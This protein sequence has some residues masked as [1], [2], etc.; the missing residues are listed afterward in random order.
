M[1]TK[2]YVNTIYDERSK[3]IIIGLTGRTGSGCSE[4]AKILETE[5]FCDLHLRVPKNQDYHTKDDRKYRIVYDYAKKNW[6]PFFVLKMSDIIFS[7][8]LQYEFDELNMI[9]RN[10]IEHWDDNF[11]NGFDENF[12]ESYAL[13]HD[14]LKSLL[15]AEKTLKR[16]NSEQLRKEFE[17]IARVT[18]LHNSFK[19]KIRKYSC[20]VGDES[21]RANVYSYLWQNMANFIRRNG[22]IKDINSNSVNVFCLARRANDFI[23]AIRKYNNSNRKNTLICIDAFR[24]AYEAQYFQ[25]RYAAFYLVSINTEESERRRRLGNLTDEQI[26]NLDEIESPKKFKNSLDKFTNQ[27]I[28]ACLELSDIHLYNPRS[29]TKENFYLAKQLIKY[30]VLMKHPGIVTP[31]HIERCM[32]IACNAKLN[33]G[34]LSRQVGACITDENYSVKAIGWNDV[35]EGQIPCNLRDINDLVKNKDCDTFSTY[36]IEDGKFNEQV[37]EIYSKINFDILNGRCYQY[38]FK[39]VFNSIDNKKNQVHTRA[40][41]AEENVFLQ[42]SKYGGIG[43]K[44]GNLFTT[45]SPCELCSKKAYQLGIKNIYYID[46]YPGISVKHI[47]SFKNTHGDMPEMHLF[48]GAVGKAY[49]ILYSQKLA[50][51]DELNYLTFE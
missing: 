45:A 29:F 20:E 46:P 21:S 2:E 35:P 15:N 8:V 23:K 37:S 17:L 50:I 28:A 27:N 5:N 43:I 30:I 39:D 19:E 16:E 9:F 38:C 7:F 24:N 48:I 12:K 34:C 51:K 42:I 32:Q 31:T 25:D 4:A 3:F 6:E 44:S 33:S 26:E 36:E 18:C 11:L 22:D 10:F 14:E 13:A 49:T 1:N 47:L 40:L 41:H